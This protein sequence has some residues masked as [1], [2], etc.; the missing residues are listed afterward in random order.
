MLQSRQVKR[1]PQDSI[2]ELIIL[3]KESVSRSHN[4]CQNIQISILACVM[5][6]DYFKRTSPYLVGLKIFE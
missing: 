4:Y 3:K 1:T 2:N 6:S 5:S